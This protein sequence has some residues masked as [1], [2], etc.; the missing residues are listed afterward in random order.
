MASFKER[1]NSRKVDSNDA[2]TN[3]NRSEKLR[4]SRLNVAN[5]E[6]IVNIPSELTMADHLSTM[7]NVIVPNRV[8]LQSMVANNNDDTTTH[9]DTS[10]GQTDCNSNANHGNFEAENIVS[11]TQETVNDA[12]FNVKLCSDSL[13]SIINKCDVMDAKLQM[14]PKSMAIEQQHITNNEQSYIAVTTASA[15]SSQNRKMMDD[16]PKRHLHISDSSKAKSKPLESDTSAVRSSQKKKKKDRERDKDRDKDKLH[17]HKSH[18]SSKSSSSSS[19]SD[20]KSTVSASN[21]KI[22]VSHHQSDHDVGRSQSGNQ[23]S[24]DKKNK[25]DGKS[26]KCKSP[27]TSSSTKPTSST[28]QINSIELNGNHSINESASRN[29]LIKLD[30]DLS[31]SEEKTNP[32]SQQINSNDMT[33]NRLSSSEELNNVPDTTTTDVCTDI[34]PTNASKMSPLPAAKPHVLPKSERKVFVPSNVSFPERKPTEAAGIVIKKDYLPPPTKVIKVEKTRDDV[35]RVLNYDTEPNAVRS[36]STAMSV[37]GGD[38]KSIEEKIKV[39]PLEAPIKI[40]PSDKK[41]SDEKQAKKSITNSHISENKENSMHKIETIKKPK[42]E[43]SPSVKI[44]SEYKSR[45]SSSEKKE[46]KTSSGSSE[47]RH[48]SSSSKS[49]SKSSSH[50]SS[51]SSGGSNRDCSRCYRRSKIKRVNTGVQCCKYGEPFKYITPTATPLKSTQTL[52]CNMTDSL[53]SDLKYG[54]YFHIEV[55]TNGGASIVHMYQN[56]IDSLSDSEMEEL[57]EEFFRVVFSEN[58]DGYAHHVMG[59]VHDAARYIPD[60]LEHMADNYSTLTVKAGVL[61]RNSDIET[62][63]LVQYYEQV[64]KNYSHGT[65]RYG[66]LHQISL[67]GKVHEEVGGYF[68]DLLGRLEANPF[69]NKTMPWGEK[70][71]VQMDPRL[72]NDGPILWVRPGE[73]LV[74][75]AELTKTPMKRQR[76]R[77]NELRNLQYL[78]RLSEARETMFEDRTKA[79]ADHVG[80]GHERMTTAAVGVLKAVQCGQKD[81]QNRVTKDVV[82]FYA[83]DFPHLVEK[84]QLD[85]HEPPI[86]QC[87]Q[88]IEDAKLNQ[89][90]REGIKY[91]RINLYDNDIYFL[92]R[93]IIHQFRTVTAVTSIAWHLRLRQYYPGIEVTNEHND[94]NLAETPHYKEK[95]TILPHPISA[96]VEKKTQTPVKRSHDGKPKKDK[97]DPC[98]SP[99]IDEQSTPKEVCIKADE[100]KIDMRKLVIEHKSHKK[101]S[102]S[103]SSSNSIKKHSSSSSLSSSISKKDK[104]KEKDREKHKSSSGSDLHRSHSSSKK[105]HSSDKHRRDESRK[106]SSSSSTNHSSSSSEKHKSSETSA[107]KEPEPPKVQTVPLEPIAMDVSTVQTE[108]IDS[109]TEKNEA[110]LPAQVSPSY[111]MDSVDSPASPTPEHAPTFANPVVQS[112]QPPVMPCATLKQNPPPPPQPPSFDILPP[113]P[114]LPKDEIPPPPPPPPEEEPQSSKSTS[115]SPDSSTQQA[116]PAP[117][118]RKNNNGDKAAP[119]SDLL[120]SIMASMD[121]PRNASNF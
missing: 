24:H 113:L 56:E 9:S 95:Q 66:P 89:L 26:D 16:E 96:E 116:S 32:K 60:L 114:P 18:S 73:Q 72:S 104:D 88:W 112:P 10:S 101:S 35:T 4:L 61:G 77:I 13:A 34:E 78:P 21:G 67:V 75:T 64:V 55:H 99:M 80:H 52:A 121:S 110:T 42:E 100:A 118:V 47:H 12:A 44:K 83:G 68:P 115:T 63:T 17:R 39:E 29:E 46:S 92:P 97:K 57:T 27:S 3:E 120:G 93:N 74:P 22:Q 62:S 30:G 107:K 11:S 69:L 53:Y 36:I 59:I 84:L 51:S 25:S 54:R 98:K 81:M 5:S 106:S 1:S 65:F 58:E 45:E 105:S 20:S 91:A 103:G 49:S 86:S 48:H 41:I 50:R 94:P 19:S 31:A 37:I 90:R 15:L 119:S 111:P 70:S 102:S 87:V 82:A 38:T 2:E 117:K 28:N 109:N 23:H 43:N 8:Q 108:E 76:T 40:E 79:H 71:I 7:D 6:F 85:L 33:N 14:P